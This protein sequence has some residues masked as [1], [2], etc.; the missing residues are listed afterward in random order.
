MARSSHK[1]QDLAEQIESLNKVNTVE[2]VSFN[3]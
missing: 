2:I 3:S 1:I